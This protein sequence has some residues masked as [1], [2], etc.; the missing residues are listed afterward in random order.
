MNLKEFSGYCF[1]EIGAKKGYTRY[2]NI[3]YKLEN[4]ILLGFGMVSQRCHGYDIEFEIVPLSCGIWI[5][6][7]G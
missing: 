5:Y 2:R 6:N 4:E 7:T 3:W 1:D